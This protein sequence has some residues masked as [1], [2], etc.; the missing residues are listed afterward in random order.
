MCTFSS[1]VKIT[2]G[3]LVLA[4]AISQCSMFST[5][6]VPVDCDVVKNQQQAGLT[7]AAIA[8][9]LGTSVDQVAACHG[10]KK[11]DPLVY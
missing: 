1:K 4:C 9:N 7:D 2:A 5:A 3:M 6:K 10:P 11:A 8:T